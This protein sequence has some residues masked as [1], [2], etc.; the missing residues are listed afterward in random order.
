MIDMHCSQSDSCIWSNKQTKGEF[1]WFHKVPE[2]WNLCSRVQMPTTGEPQ[3]NSVCNGTCQEPAHFHIMKPVRTWGICFWRC[4]SLVS[5][6]CSNMFGHAQP[7][8]KRGKKIA[9]LYCSD[10][11]FDLR[12]TSARCESSMHV[13]DNRCHS[14]QSTLCRLV[15]IQ[16]KSEQF[17][18][19]WPDNEKNI[20]SKCNDLLAC[21]WSIHGV[22]WFPI[23][24][25][26]CHK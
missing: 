5:R 11:A 18:L 25:N 9:L 22:R 14:I 20:I 21:S 7:Q 24:D 23:H 17:V 12:L 1:I 2:Y 15:R 16:V 4:S 10:L 3:I 26:V 13:W 6:V 19:E 8:R